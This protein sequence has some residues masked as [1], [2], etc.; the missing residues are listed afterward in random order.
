MHLRTDHAGTAN[1]KNRDISHVT[2]SQ[3]HFATSFELHEVMIDNFYKES[4]QTPMG[5]TPLNNSSPA[6]TWLVYTPLP[7]ESDCNIAAY[8]PLIAE[9]C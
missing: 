2:R 4:K 3:L 7:Y 5:A 6:S 1:L 9:F 8:P